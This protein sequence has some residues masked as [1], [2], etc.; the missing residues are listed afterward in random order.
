MVKDYFPVF[1]LSYLI[2]FRRAKAALRRS[3]EAPQRTVEYGRRP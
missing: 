2:A 3:A 1:W